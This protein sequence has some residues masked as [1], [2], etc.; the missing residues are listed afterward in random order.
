MPDGVISRSEEVQTYFSDES[1]V[2]EFCF[3]GSRE[4]ESLMN[5]RLFSHG[6]AA[7]VRRMRRDGI[8]CSGVGRERAGLF[9]T[10][11]SVLIAAVFAVLAVAACGAIALSSVLQNGVFYGCYRVISGEPGPTAYMR[12]IDPSVGQKCSGLETAMNFNQSGPTGPTGATG[13]T[14]VTGPSG[15]TG[16]TGVTGSTGATGPSGSTG[17]TGS[18]GP[19]GATGATGPTGTATLTTTFIVGP[20]NI[21]YG[22]GLGYYGK[23]N[24]PS[25]YAMAVG[26]FE[27]NPSGGVYESYPGSSGTSW[28]VSAMN[29]GVNVY[30]TCIKGG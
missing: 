16:P 9:R 15:A 10:R 11:Q 13:A 19:T 28:F 7:R 25:G 20:V 21:P 5:R 23:V 4:M 3:V 14:G 2:A 26:G 30:A 18:T 17:A 24:C 29:T 6:G 8:A 1:Y 12:I 27:G 22:G